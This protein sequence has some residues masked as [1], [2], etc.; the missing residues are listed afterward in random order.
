[1]DN[2]INILKTPTP[3]GCEINLYGILNEI[4]STTPFQSRIDNIGNIQYIYNPEADFKIVLE[5]HIDEIGF[6]VNFIDDGGLIYV[7]PIGTID[8]SILNGVRVRVFHNNIPYLGLLYSRLSS[9]QIPSGYDGVELVVDIGLRGKQVKELISIGDF[10][11]FDH[12][13]DI[14]N[15]AYVMSPGIDNRG[16]VSALVSALQSLNAEDLKNV[17]ILLCLSAREEIGIVAIAPY[18]EEFNPQ[19]I[20]SFDSCFVSDAV[21]QRARNVGNVV[22]DGGPIVCFDPTCSNIFNQSI[23]EIAKKAKIEIQQYVNIYPGRGLNSTRL[24]TVAHRSKV[25]SI[26]LP[27]RYIHSPYE[28]CSIRD[29][30][31]L[32]SLTVCIIKH[33]KSL[34]MQ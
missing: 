15:D 17:G 11:V 8:C 9:Q 7:K 2:L 6:M 24:S 23:V 19:V 13:V 3:S 33:C 32:K 26:L 31:A 29:Y 25:T 18:I 4:F 16:C 10:A 21:C 5:A 34:I 27:T 20:I 22:L 30:N 28:M 12:T 1:M 14:L